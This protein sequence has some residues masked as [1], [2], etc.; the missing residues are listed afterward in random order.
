M[1]ARVPPP[2]A[3]S[4]WRR[5]CSSTSCERRSASRL[6]P[7]ARRLHQ[8]F[9]PFSLRYPEEAKA[10][11]ATEL[12]NPRIALPSSRGAANR[13]PDLVARGGPID[14]LQYE[15][16][17]EAEFEFGD[18]N[19]A[20]RAIFEGDNIAAANL[21]LYLEAELLKKAFNGEVK[22]GFQ[23]DLP[24]YPPRSARRI[25]MMEA[26]ACGWRCR[27][28]RGRYAVAANAK[29]RPFRCAWRAECPA[30]RQFVAVICWREGR[31]KTCAVM[32]VRPIVRDIANYLKKFRVHPDS[33]QR[34]RSFTKKR[35][36]LHS[37]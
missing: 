36:R 21:A 22:C 35:W 26:I 29:S 24:R 31:L 6:G 3:G 10:Q 11:Q 18:H 37:G 1:G 4:P 34:R 16:Q 8:D 7:P 14:A 2:I 33:D 13:K 30:S 20:W 27:H 23:A 9:N 25:E 32:Q 5:R 12:A 15:F 17:V 28:G 19:K